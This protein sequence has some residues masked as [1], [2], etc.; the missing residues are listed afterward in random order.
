[1]SNA[2]QVAEQV[3]DSASFAFQLWAYRNKTLARSV[4]SLQGPRG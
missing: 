2:S 1:M 4:E 3:P